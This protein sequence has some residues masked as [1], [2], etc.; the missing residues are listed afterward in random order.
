MATALIYSEKPTSFNKFHFET[1]R[2]ISAKDEITPKELQEYLAYRIKNYE[3]SKGTTF[4]VV[5]GINCIKTKDGIVDLGRTD[6][7]LIQNFDNQV[8][9][10]LRNLKSNKS[11]EVIWNDMNFK[12]EL[13]PIATKEEC[14]FQPPFNSTF[15][16]TESSKTDL[17]SLAKKVADQGKPYVVVLAFSY[18]F[19]SSIKGFFVLEP[20]KKKLT[21]T[22]IQQKPKSFEK[23]HCKSDTF[24]PASEVK[25]TLIKGQPKPQN[26]EKFHCESNTFITASDEINAQE[27]QD[28]LTYRIKKGD[29]FEGTTFCTLAGIHHGLDHNRQVVPGHTDHTLLQG[30]FYKVFNG[31][32]NLKDQKSGRSI[33]NEMNFQKEFI[34]IT[35]DE[36]QSSREFELSANSKA[37]LRDLAK[38]LVKQT[39]PYVVIFASCFSYQSEIRDFLVEN[40]VLATL[41]ITN[42]RGMI[43]G[44]KLFALDKVQ[45]EVLDELREVIYFWPVP[46][47]IQLYIE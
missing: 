29:F 11:V 45:R 17:K 27:V 44:G 40:G 5:T 8:F 31:L 13:H 14:S 23:F 21:F 28:Y 12:K 20:P 47:I 35:S 7:N 10:G 25:V 46:Y 6:F 33:W 22:Q 42:D 41:D 32:S 37:E 43:S 19:Q 2:L 18:S 3:F 15:T 4:C 34:A 39:K 16:L 1:N 38:K 26:F 36:I 30:F 9:G 24:S